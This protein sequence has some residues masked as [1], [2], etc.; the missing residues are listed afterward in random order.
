MTS[1]TVLEF[2]AP[3]TQLQS[4][5]TLQSHKENTKLQNEIVTISS[6]ALQ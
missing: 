3:F 1:F 4:D 6:N 2:C 5:E